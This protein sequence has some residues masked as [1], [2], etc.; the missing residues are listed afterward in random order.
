MSDPHDKQ[1]IEKIE[2]IEAVDAAGDTIEEV[3]IELVE[4][5][6]HAKHHHGEPAPSA[7][8]YAFRVDKQRVVVD[9]PLIDGKQILAEVG[10]TP[11]KFKL[12]QHKRGHQPV[13][14]EAHQVVDLRTPG[15]ERFT[16]MPKDTTEGLTDG[17]GRRD[18]RLPA[19]DEDYL[20]SLS[21][22]WETAL[23][24]NMR[25]VFIHGWRAPPGYNHA[26]VTLAL[27]IPDNYSDAQIDMVYFRQHLARLDG[28]P[29]RNLSDQPI[30][31]ATW[32]RWSRHR[33]NANPWRAGVDDIASHLGLI[34]DWLG[35]EFA[36]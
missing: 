19:S 5:E 9:K 17:E 22:Q 36:Q 20:N 32:Q 2:I 30:C 12:Y 21:L 35:R 1:L 34:D 25:W 11:D 23:D 4:L 14:I 6:E 26:I 8:H 28:R 7:R 29:I 10:K 3:I 24:R 18:F 27:L 33:T 13:Q 31:G 15:V 16:T